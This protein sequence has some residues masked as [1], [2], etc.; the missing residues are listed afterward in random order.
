[1]MLFALMEPGLG[2]VWVSRKAAS[3]RLKGEHVAP[4]RELQECLKFSGL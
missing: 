3:Q 2:L 4:K 1:M